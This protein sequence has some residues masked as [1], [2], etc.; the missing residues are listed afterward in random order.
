MKR[1]SSARSRARENRPV[2]ETLY[3]KV[4]ARVYEDIPKH[5]AYRSGIVVQKY[6]AAFATKHGERRSPYTGSRRTK[7]SGLTRW[8]AEKWVNQRGEVGY[9]RKSDIYRPSKR[10][11]RKTPLT[12]SELSK[13]E[14]GRARRVKA[15]KG[16]VRRFRRSTSKRKRKSKKTKKTKKTKKKTKTKKTKKTKKKTKTK[17]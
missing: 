4:K 8:F 13:R 14:I 12:H 7:R 6:K 15:T 2:D 1:R 5:S 3:E 9:R 10:I 17:T 11:T 16:R